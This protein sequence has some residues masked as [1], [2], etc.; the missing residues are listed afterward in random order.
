MWTGMLLLLLLL[1][2]III[3]DSDALYYSVGMHGEA[4][5]KRLNARGQRLQ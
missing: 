2:L 1:M 3:Q 4:E 5:V